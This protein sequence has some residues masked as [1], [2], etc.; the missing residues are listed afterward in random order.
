MKKYSMFLTLL[1]FISCY[2]LFNQIS[3]LHA[4]IEH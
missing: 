4:L 1:F 3:Y 2:V